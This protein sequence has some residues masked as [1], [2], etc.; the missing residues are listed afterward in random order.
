MARVRENRRSSC[1]E[2]EGREEM[3]PV[4]TGLLV[5][6]PVGIGLGLGLAIKSALSDSEVPFEA[7]QEAIDRVAEFRN[8]DGVGFENYTVR[9][10][11]LSVVL[12][13]APWAKIPEDL[14][15]SE[16]PGDPPKSPEAVIDYLEEYLEADVT[17]KRSAKIRKNFES[18]EKEW[19]K[20]DKDEESSK[21]GETPEEE[22]EED[23]LDEEEESRPKKPTKK[24][25]TKKKK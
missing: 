16:L 9:G 18:L 5:L 4:V 15:P 11:A 23:P 24:K 3:S 19:D 14:D 2:E 10:S 12:T 1:E 17:D 8:K 6:A 21:S 7:S 25:T 20:K 13:N 22:E